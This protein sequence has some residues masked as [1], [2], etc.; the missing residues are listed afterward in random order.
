[1]AGGAATTGVNWAKLGILDD[2]GT[3]I[4]DPSKGGIGTDG[5]YLAV[6]KS[7]GI[8]EA[9]IS[10]IEQ[11]G[12]AVYSNNGIGRYSYGAQEPSMTLNALDMDYDVYNK[13]KGYESDGKG[14]YVLSSKK[15]PN[16]AVLVASQDYA[17][18]MVY[19]AFANSNVVETDLDK[20]T[21]NTKAQ[22]D[23]IS[24]E[25]DALDP[26]KDGIFTDSQG[27][28][29]PYK[30]YFAQASG[31]DEAA[32]MKEVFGGYTAATSGTTQG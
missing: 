7:V 20:K 2:T 4:S 1:M 28:Q 24:L 14:G 10:G 6:N 13:I 12:T 5:I 15:K 11:K 30:V 31:F 19:L 16:V 26:L 18:N 32:M 21:D 27:Q 3:L 22:D 25:I 23:T 29:K 17:G 8:I 9:K